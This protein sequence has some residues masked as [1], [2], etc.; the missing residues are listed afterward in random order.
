MKYNQLQLKKHRKASRKGRGIATGRGKT[1]GR[2]TKGQGSRKS[3]N[4]RSGFE[5]GQT[6]IYMRIPKLR[7]FKSKRTVAENIYTYQLDSLK[8]AVIDN[9]VL[10][11]AG[12]SSSPYVVVKIIKK[13]E[14]QSKKTVKLQGASNGAQDQ[15]S[16][17]GGSFEQTARLARPAKSVP[18]KSA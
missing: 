4:V 10:Y 8:E 9:K 1:A 5:G 2:G 7:G 12:L 13:G 18:E 3:G 14:L 16:S 11:E 17:V 15:I 6:P